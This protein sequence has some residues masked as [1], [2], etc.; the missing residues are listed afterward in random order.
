MVYGSCISSLAVYMLFFLPFPVT[1][2]DD[3]RREAGVAALE[4]GEEEKVRAMPG[5]I[6][7]GLKRRTWSSMGGSTFF[8]GVNGVTVFY[9]LVFSLLRGEGLMNEIHGPRCPPRRHR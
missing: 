3:I 6:L 1:H 8:R 9:L 2:F 7:I 5:G 4:S